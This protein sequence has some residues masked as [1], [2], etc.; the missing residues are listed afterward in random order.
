V[1]EQTFY[2]G[3]TYYS[4]FYTSPLESQSFV[5]LS[6]LLFLLLSF[7]FKSHLLGAQ[8]VLAH[9]RRLNHGLIDLLF[10]WLI[11]PR[12]VRIQRDNFLHNSA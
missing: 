9:L 2:S 11:H 6:L 8:V 3:I 5:V 12:P 10:V 4:L 7:S 1:Y